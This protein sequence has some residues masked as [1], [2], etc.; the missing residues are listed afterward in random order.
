MSPR[1]RR[2]IKADEELLR[3]AVGEHP[4]DQA[5]RDLEA[6]VR[7]LVEENARLRALATENARL[8]Q[9]V[10]KLQPQ[11]SNLAIEE[12]LLRPVEAGLDGVPLRTA[13]TKLVEP[14]GVAL[15]I[16]HE[17]LEREGLTVHH[18]V[19]LTVSGVKLASALNLMLEPLGLRHWVHEGALHVMSSDSLLVIRN[20]PVV[21][22]LPQSVA[23]GVNRVDIDDPFLNRPGLKSDAS[24]ELD[25]IAQLIVE[26]VAPESWDEL[27]GSG[28]AVP[29]VA[30]L[31]LVVR[32]TNDVHGQIED[33]LEQLRPDRGERELLGIVVGDD[34]PAESPESDRRQRIEAALDSPITMKVENV[35]LMEIAR[36]I[37]EA[38]G[39][40]ILIDS[41][42]LAEEG[43]SPE[44]ITSIQAEALPLREFLPKLL[45]PMRLGY[46][47]RFRDE[48]L[49][50]TSRLRAGGELIVVNYAVP[51]LVAGQDS[52]QRGFE[53]SLQTLAQV[54]TQAIE[55]E[56]WESAGGPGTAKPYAAANSLVVRQQRRQHRLLEDFLKALRDKNQSRTEL[57]EGRPVAAVCI[58]GKG[59]ERSRPTEHQRDALRKIETRPGSTLSAARIRQDIDTIYRTRWFYSVESRAVN[60][61]AGVVVVF[62][63]VDRP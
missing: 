5:S 27:G 9:L 54:I 2:G 44:R 18:P 63:V 26:S 21:D 50:I 56:S 23:A 12:A 58:V 28:T 42:G 32:Q 4:Q 13:L 25:R 40:N 43:T 48:V 41:R 36:L 14:Y 17:G 11:L 51:D 22:L 59:Q 55:P 47:I 10:R 8:L 57:I 6:T 39:I 61:P 16:D 29:Y 52:K 35:R 49:V 62:E 1:N 3:F 37:R 45:R 53:N 38:A 19:S 7:S 31:S 46:H 60:T 34:D 20:Y 15:V 30:T 33:L 24:K